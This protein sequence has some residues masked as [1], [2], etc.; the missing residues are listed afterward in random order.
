M[1]KKNGQLCQHEVPDYDGR[2]TDT[3]FAAY[4]A[5]FSLVEDSFNHLVAFTDSLKAAEK[6]VSR[7]LA[8][9]LKQSSEA[10][11]TTFERVETEWQVIEPLIK[12][13]RTDLLVCKRN[14]G[15]QIEY[16]IIERWPETSP[17]AQVHGA[18]QV[19][20]AS[21]EPQNLLRAFVEDEKKTLQIWA[22][23]I[24]GEVQ[25]RLDEQFPQ[26]DMSL[27][28]AAISTRCLKQIGMEQA[29]APEQSQAHD[30]QMHV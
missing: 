17:F 15:G 26:Q 13:S 12:T 3:E 28:A 29:D 9:G 21:S 7:L 10:E 8:S 14:V 18:Y 5:A 30:M 19:Q 25:E 22:E 4:K 20:A 27:V 24:T 23:D 11:V 1:I 2:L 16:A 6:T